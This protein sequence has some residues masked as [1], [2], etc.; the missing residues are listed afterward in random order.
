MVGTQRLAGILVFAGLVAAT[1]PAPVRAQRSVLTRA[2]LTL[3]APAD[4]RL[5]DPSLDRMARGGELRLRRSDADPMIAGRTHEHLDQYFNGVPVYGADIARQIANGVTVS[6]FGTVY[7]NLELNVEPVLTTEGAADAIRRDSG[8][9]LGGPALP[10][11]LILPDADRARLVYHAYA[12][13][14]EGAFE[15]FIDAVTG[16]I[17]DRRDAAQ[18]EAAIGSGVGVLGDTKKLS[19]FHAGGVYLTDDPL[20]PPLLRTYDMREN[21]TRTLSAL[22]GLLFLGATDEGTDTDNTWTDPAV[23]DAHAYVGYVYDFYYRRFGRQ[24]LDNRNGQLRSIVHPVSRSA[25]FTQSSSV[26]GSYYANAFFATGLDIM[27]F[28]EGLPANYPSAQRWNYLSGALDVVG[29]ELTHG[30]TR[31]TSNLIYLNESGALNEAFS[32]MM[33]TAIEFFYQPPGGGPL[34]SDYLCAEDVVTPGGIRS[35]ANPIAYDDPDHYSRKVI[36]NGDN[37]GVHTNS[38]IASHAYYLAIEGGVNRTSG[39]SVTGVGFSNREQ[40]EKVMYRAFTQLMPASATYAVARATT[41][42]A[43]RELYGEG[44]PAERAIMQAWTAVGVN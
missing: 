30:V 32:D 43:A 17:V 2:T 9:E 3:T 13:S 24:G 16:A 29:H 33:G 44:S 40:I 11:L 36:T 14:T 31:Y 25:A 7:S 26:L 20:R 21:L 1:G 27:V 5:W 22:N 6:V 8:V 35:L 34:Q 42:Q 12:Y 41:I 28:G 37:G 18:R 39:L 10:Q 38:A 23:V 19:V 4:L 15:Y